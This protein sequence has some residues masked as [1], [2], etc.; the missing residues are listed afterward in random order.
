MRQRSQVKFQPYPPS[1]LSSL[2]YLCQGLSSLYLK[3]FNGH[4]PT[5][6]GGSPFHFGWLCN[7]KCRVSQWGTRGIWMQCFFI[8]LGCTC[9]MP[10][11]Y[12]YHISL[13]HCGGK[14]VPSYI[15]MSSTRVVPSYSALGSVSSLAEAHRSKNPSRHSS[16]SCQGS[17]AHVLILPDD[18]GLWE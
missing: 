10:S 15:F 2:Q 11:R 9:I 17:P 18:S 14:K 6:F 5:A 1:S 4:E 3:S 12:Q 7:I 16:S 13:N 8:V